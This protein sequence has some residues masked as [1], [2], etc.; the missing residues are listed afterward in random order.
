M[1]TINL[2]L[3]NFLQVYSAENERRGLAAALLDPALG[4][5]AANKGDKGEEDG[6]GGQGY[7]EGRASAF[8]E[9]YSGSAAS[10]EESGSAGAADDDAAAVRTREEEG[11]IWDEDAE[12][13]CAN[14]RD[15]Q[16]QR[17]CPG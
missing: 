6:H 3:P 13:T 16:V 11:E 5:A 15:G 9:H 2:P 10:G 8:D 4:A 12:T 14:A 1:S 7:E 17:S